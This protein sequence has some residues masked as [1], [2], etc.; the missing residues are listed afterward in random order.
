MIVGGKQIRALGLRNMVQIRLPGVRIEGGSAALVKPIDLLLAQQK[1]AAKKEF[2][3]AMGMRFGVGKGQSRTPGSSENLPAVDAEMFAKS[4]DIGHEVPCGV[5]LQRRVGSALAAATLIE[6][7]DAVLTGMEEAALLGFGAATGA[8][9]QEDDRFSSGSSA[10]FEVNL[11]DGGDREHA[12]AI[13]LGGRVEPGERILGHRQ[14]SSSAGR[15]GDR[16]WIRVATKGA[17][18]ARKGCQT[19]ERLNRS[20][21]GEIRS[22]CIWR[23]LR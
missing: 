14:E 13:R 19:F 23:T 11:V 21:P 20:E 6:I 16:R 7:N 2:A 18:K 22:C 8:A 15:Q 3:H 1:D 17:L 9:V 5:V 10:F 4:L 12:G